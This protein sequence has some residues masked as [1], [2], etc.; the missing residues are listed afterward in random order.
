M[1][2][3]LGLG[4]INRVPWQSDCDSSSRCVPV[5]IA[6][7][8]RSQALRLTE[9][10]KE[11]MKHFLDEVSSLKKGLSRSCLVE[12]TKARP[13]LARRNMTFPVVDSRRRQCGCDPAAGLSLLC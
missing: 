13:S 11:K 1:N 3:S 8:C 7:D 6:G 12:R 9:Y 2:R 10:G 4:P 5:S